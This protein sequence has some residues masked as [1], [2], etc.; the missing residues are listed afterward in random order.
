MP[1]PFLQD[2][3]DPAKARDA[4]AAAVAML[5][6]EPALDAA[7]AAATERFDMDEQ[8]RLRARKA[9]LA[10]QLR[11]ISQGPGEPGKVANTI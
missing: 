7:I 8:A 3:A 5:T 11:E 10:E 9:S 6:E 2:E 1:W 4:L